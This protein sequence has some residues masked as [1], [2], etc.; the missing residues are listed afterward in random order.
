M[1]R[2]LV[3]CALVLAGASTACGSSSSTPTSPGSASPGG[4]FADL[5]GSW[6]GTL[7]SANLSTRSITLTVVQS[8]NCVDG[9]W[10]SSTSDWH[11]AISGLATA[12]SF[13]G[14]LSFERSASGGGQCDATAPVSG[15]AGSTLRFTAD[16]LTAVGS[17]SGELPRSI[18]VTLRR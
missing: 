12:D 4:P 13:S 16:T 1:S 11:G 2:M 9:A 15:A 14:F 6:T 8:G 17:C 7:E 5:S 10:I 3:L 18:V